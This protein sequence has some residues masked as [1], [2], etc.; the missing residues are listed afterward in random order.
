MF[1]NTF[2]RLYSLS[3]HSLHFL[4]SF[5]HGLQGPD[6]GGPRE[7]WHDLHSKIDGPAAYDVLTNFEERWLKA[8]KRHGIRKLKRS[9]DDAL[10]KI[11]RIQDII[12]INDAQYLNDNHPESWH[13]QV[14]KAN[15]HL[16]FL[17]IIYH[18]NDSYN[19]YVSS[20]T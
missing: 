15:L 8:S 6:T 9:F 5:N 2:P 13:V 16:S 12:G 3:Q 10:L 7:P 14:I 19:S 11:E 18:F 1:I 17:C 20:S 4:K